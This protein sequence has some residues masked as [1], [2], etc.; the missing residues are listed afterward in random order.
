ME[1]KIFLKYFVNG[2]SSKRNFSIAHWNLNS[3]AGE[4]FVKKSQLEAYNTMN[5][6]DLIYLSETW[7]DSATS[8]NS[9]DCL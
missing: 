7:L 5:S 1:T 4:N 8:I 2:C 6:Y 3:I 9:Y